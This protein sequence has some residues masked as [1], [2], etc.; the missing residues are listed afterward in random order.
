[1]GRGAGRAARRSVQL[2]MDAAGRR[3][4]FEPAGIEA[5]S[6]ADQKVFLPKAHDMTEPST[7]A[8][9]ALLDSSDA[10]GSPDISD[11][12]SPTSVS[13]TP[14]FVEVAQE[15]SMRR[16]NSTAG[17][18]PKAGKTLRSQNSTIGASE[19]LAAKL[20][21]RL[22]KADL[23][24]GAEVI[25]PRTN[26]GQ[27]SERRSRVNSELARALNKQQQRISVSA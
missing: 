14:R 9:S 2:Q 3:E 25:S 4:V 15:K 27:T 21:K 20:E 13:P 17:L 1:M 10:P 22:S 8:S 6:P 24:D 11:N 16:Q 7:A 18:S 5:A 19:E 12:E 23:A 26:S